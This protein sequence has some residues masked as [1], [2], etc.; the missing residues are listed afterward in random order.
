M[1]CAT[2]KRHAIQS[3]QKNRKIHAMKIALPN[4]VFFS[5][6]VSIGSWIKV[7]TSE[8]AMVTDADVKAAEGK[9]AEIA[10][11][12][13]QNMAEMNDILQKLSL[14]SATQSEKD[15]LSSMSS[16]LASMTKQVEASKTSE[17]QIRESRN[18][19]HAE[20]NL[21]ADEIESV[22]KII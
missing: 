6:E 21:K 10:L 12:A 17:K 15:K 19:Y 16:K 2:G 11:D 3:V 8:E 7:D 5:D 20:T 14:G 1:P 13:R 18:R 9:T 22:L 4:D